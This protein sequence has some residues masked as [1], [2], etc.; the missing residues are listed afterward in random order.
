MFFH[1]KAPYPACSRRPTKKRDSNAAR[2]GTYGV[3]WEE[4]NLTLRCV[5]NP[6]GEGLATQINLA[7]QA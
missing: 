1:L 2:N 4:F 7:S 5:S 6:I 3:F